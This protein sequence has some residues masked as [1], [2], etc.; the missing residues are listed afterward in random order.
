MNNGP[1]LRREPKRF[2]GE[3]ISRFQKDTKEELYRI[4]E[5]SRS[6]F[7][8][9]RIFIVQPALSKKGASTSQL[10]LLAVTE[11]YLAETYQLQFGVIASP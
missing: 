6:A 11:N 5:S 3:E 8:R 1:A 9:T 7:V 2:K 10:E 4:K